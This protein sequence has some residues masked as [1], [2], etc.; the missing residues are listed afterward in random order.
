MIKSIKYALPI[1]FTILF[2]NI[3]LGQNYQVSMSAW[4]GGVPQITTYQEMTGGKML[5]N[6]V[7]IMIAKE[8]SGN[9]IKEWKLTAKLADDHYNTQDANYSFGAQHA[10]LSF[11]QETY[12]GTTAA[13]PSNVP[14]TLSKFNEVTLVES[15][16]PF[17]KNQYVQRQLTYNLFIQ[18]G[19]HLLANPNGD[20]RANYEFRLYGRN[21]SNQ[22]YSLLATYASSNVQSGAQINYVGNHGTQSIE[23]QNGANQYDF[24]FSQASDY[25]NGK[26]IEIQN[27]LK[28]TTHNTYN[29]MVKSSNSEFVSQ[30]TSS[31]IPISV[32]RVEAALNPSENNVVINGPLT[33]SS[34]DQTLVTRTNTNPKTLEYD[35]RFFIPANQIQASNQAA[36]YTAYIYF[37]IVPN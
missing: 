37:T 9:R 10:Q 16:V 24:V 23:L 6:Q 33:M 31:T 13:N 26:S 11:S 27:G 21:N 20:Y 14:V 3:G 8:Y 12:Q 2:I 35:I 5:N 22:S 7:T 17:N 36:T 15:N 29:L 30:T 4:T 18:G 32:L 19:S 1:I 25:T 34:A 28:V